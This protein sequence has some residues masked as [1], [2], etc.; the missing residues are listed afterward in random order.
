MAFWVMILNQFST[1]LMPRLAL[2]EDLA[3]GPRP[4]RQRGSWYR[5][6]CSRA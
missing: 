5:D 4:G 1:W 2:G 3:G 6:G